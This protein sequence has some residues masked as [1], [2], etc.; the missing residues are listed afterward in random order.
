MYYDLSE[1][2][3]TEREGTTLYDL[4][5][6]DQ[7]GYVLGYL[8]WNWRPTA[9]LTFN[10]GLHV[11]YLGVSE[12]TSIEPRLSASWAFTPLQ[13][14]NVGFGVHRQPQALLVYFGHPDNRTLDFTTALHYVLGYSYR[15]T[16]QV[17]LKLEGYYKD[18]SD[19]PVDRD[20]L[21]SFSLLNSGANFGAVGGRSALANNGQ[22]RSYGV[23]LSAIRR[24]ADGWYATLTGSLFRQEYTGSDGIWRNGAFDNRYVVNLLAGYELHVSSDFTI[25]FSGKYTI[26]GGTPYTPVDLQRSRTFNSTYYD[27]GQRYALRNDRYSRLDVRVDFRQNFKSWSIISYFSVEN[28]LNQDNIEMRIYRPATDQVEVVNQFGIFP[29]GGFRV[30]F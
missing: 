28:L 18:I 15:I 9:E 20:S 24:F 13:S 1:S 17:M 22:G 7:T 14:I 8:N 26:A 23:E 27:Q 19:A 30:E 11:Q 10:S 5:E 2:R 6:S 25:E 21:T 4:E 29:V 3:S 16:P 12:R